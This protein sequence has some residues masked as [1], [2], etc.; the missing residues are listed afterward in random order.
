MMKKNTCLFWQM[1]GGSFLQNLRLKGDWVNLFKLYYI[2]FI[3]CCLLSIY[4][5][6]KHQF[7]LKPILM[8][9]FAAKQRKKKGGKWTARY[10]WLGLP[11]TFNFK[12]CLLKNCPNR[13]LKMSFVGALSTFT[14]A[15]EPLFAKFEVEE[16]SVLM[17]WGYLQ[18]YRFLISNFEN[19]RYLAH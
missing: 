16:H 6:Q 9:P 10:I 2:C 3:M 5:S 12:Q 7:S 17:L 19:Y 18:L 11:K 14:S 15:S 8:P 1:N 4:I 13:K